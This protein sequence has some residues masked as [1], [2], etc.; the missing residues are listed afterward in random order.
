MRGVESAT[1]EKHTSRRCKIQLVVKH[2]L[3]SGLEEEE[4]RAP[5]EKGKMLNASCLLCRFSPTS[6][7]ANIPLYDLECDVD[8]AHVL[9]VRGQNRKIAIALEYFVLSTDYERK[10]A[11]L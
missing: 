7:S 4:E 11:S 3:K 5:R 2:Q 9:E 6:S 8:I 10:D 1:R